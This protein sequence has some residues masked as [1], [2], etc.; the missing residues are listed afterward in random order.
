MIDWAYRRG[1]KPLNEYLI[2][3][4]LYDAA[5]DELGVLRRH[6]TN[7]VDRFQAH[8][9]RPIPPVASPLRA[10]PVGMAQAA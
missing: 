3:L 8:M 4:G 6:R 2:H 5:F 9:A 10:A 7:L 1:R